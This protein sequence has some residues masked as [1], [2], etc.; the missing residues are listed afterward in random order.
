M[1]EAALG[2]ESRLNG[3]QATQLLSPALGALDPNLVRI[4]EDGLVRLAA[5]DYSFDDVIAAFDAA[6]Q[7]GQPLEPVALWIDSIFMSGDDGTRSDAYIA[8]RFIGSGDFDYLV[9]LLQLPGALAA[10]TADATLGDRLADSDADNAGNGAELNVPLSRATL[11][12]VADSDGD[13]VLDGDDECPIDP[14]NSCGSN[15]ILPMITV[16]FDVVVAEPVAGSNVAIVSVILDRIVDFDVT[17]DFTAFV[18]SGDTA[19]GGVDFTE[20][21]GTVTI[22]AGER[23]ALI[24]VPVLAD[25][26]AESPE[27]FT[28]QITSVTGA[29]LGDDGIAVVTLNDTAPGSVPIVVIANDSLVA[30]ERDP[31]NMDASSSSDPGGGAL[32][33]SWLQID[34]GQ[35]VVTL[36]GAGTA[37]ASFT[38]PTTLS[39]IVLQF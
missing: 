34:N 39:P 31:V 20:I 25:A 21:S 4:V 18:A 38:A 15:P 5:D 10:I 11:P 3:L 28:V 37:E 30:N 13:L 36:N 19:E 32:S 24:A 29:T 16:G 1:L 35:P 12:W 17:I 33:F 8:S 2:R 14:Y 6:S 23:V 22:P 9:R 27:T 26:E 7:A